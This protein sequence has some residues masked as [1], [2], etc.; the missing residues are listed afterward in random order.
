MGFYLVGMS[1]ARAGQ[2]VS[3]PEGQFTVGRDLSAS[4][5]FPEDSAVSRRQARILV[6][7]GAASIEDL[8]SANGTFLNGERLTG[9]APISGGDEIRFGAQIFRLE[10]VHEGPRRAEVS[11]GDPKRITKGRATES[12]YGPRAAAGGDG[13]ANINLD[14]SGCLRWILIILAVLAAMALIGLIVM[15]LLS[16][17]AGGLKSAGSAGAGG[18]QAGGASG[19][20]QESAGQSQER[21]PDQKKPGEGE[22]QN[23]DSIEIISVK[24]DF[25]RRGSDRLVPIILIKWRNLKPQIVTRI[26]GSYD[27]F[28]AR[29]SLLLHKDN[30]LLYSG[31]EVS[32]GEI[33]EDTLQGGGI[34]VREP[35]SGTPTSAKVRVQGTK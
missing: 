26:D 31:E 10:F 14:L 35:L 25:G 33:H 19:A 24:I 30:Q 32:P 15:L 2:R 9:A 8:G 6:A 34:P 29:G 20:G 22:V 5:S 11:A 28:D 4:L 17:V 21:K 12:L 1:G 13:C 16:A 3:L 23:S 18:Q 27:I 7:N